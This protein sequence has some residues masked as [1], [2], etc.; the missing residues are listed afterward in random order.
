MHASRA[1]STRVD[2]E[3]HDAKSDHFL[4]SLRHFAIPRVLAP[5]HAP[6]ILHARQVVQSHLD[7]NTQITAQ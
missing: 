6:Y 3:N 5:N 4:G 1:A 2:I 7:M